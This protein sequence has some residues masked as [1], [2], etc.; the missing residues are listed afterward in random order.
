MSVIVAS[1]VPEAYSRNPDRNEFEMSG[2]NVHV[3]GIQND[4]M[5]GLKESQAKFRKHHADVGDALLNISGVDTVTG[6]IVDKDEPRPHYRPQPFPKMIYHAEKGELVVHDQQELEQYIGEG[7]RKEPYPRPKV[8]VMDPA[9]E[10]KAQMDE[11]AR[12]RGV[13]A[14]QND[15]LEKMAARLEALENQGSGRK[16]SA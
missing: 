14:Q 2:A 5:G 8:V 16:K 15:L 3:A 12:L 11:S 10:K 6:G 13:I 7:W 4:G 1:A 9:V